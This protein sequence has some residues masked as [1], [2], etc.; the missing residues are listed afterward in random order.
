[1]I[2]PVASAELLALTRAAAV[3]YGVV[4]RLPQVVFAYS[5]Q[6]DNVVLHARSPLPSEAAA[7]AAEAGRRIKRSPLYAAETTYDVFLCDTPALF[8]FFAPINRGVGGIAD[9]HLSRHVFLRPSRIGTGIGWSGPSGRGKRR[10][11]ARS[12]TSSPTKS[13]TIMT[14]RRLGPL[15]YGHLETW[16]REGY[17]DY[18]REGG[19]FSTSRRRCGTSTPGRTALDLEALRAP[20]PLP[21]AGRPS[22]RPERD[23]GANAAAVSR[24]AGGA[25]R[26]GASPRDFQK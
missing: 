18:V 3:V 15:G 6:A 8:A 5:T 22:A 17:A 16:Q 1:M 12:P 4:V 13:P 24:D 25:D 7:I 20:S 19:A 10:A 2:T 26:S 23:D 14:V 11:T 21:S 9:V